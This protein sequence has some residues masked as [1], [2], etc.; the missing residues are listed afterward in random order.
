MADGGVALDVPSLDCF[1]RWR[2][3]DAIDENCGLC[4]LCL[5]ADG[6]ESLVNSPAEIPE[7]GAL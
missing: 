3:V 6:S 2:T 5:L 1:I 4:G 7:S